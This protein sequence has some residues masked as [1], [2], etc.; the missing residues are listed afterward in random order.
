MTKTIISGAVLSLVAMSFNGCG[1]TTSTNLT[2]GEATKVS[3]DFGE[4][5]EKNNELT[6]RILIKTDT[7]E[8]GNSEEY[9]KD[10][11]VVDNNVIRHEVKDKPEANSTVSIGSDDVNITFPLIPSKNFTS[12]RVVEIGETVSHST[13]EKEMTFSGVTTKTEEEKKCILESKITTFDVNASLFEETYTGDIIVIACTFNEKVSF[14]DSNETMDTTDI[15]RIYY[16]KEKG[17]ILSIDN[18]C[19]VP[20]NLISVIDDSSKECEY[21]RS[22][23][24][25]LVK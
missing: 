21:K 13:S 10:N 22:T 16:Q 5:F 15:E 18:N 11:V 25:A 17:R 7:R 19:Y 6:N 12:K 2:D 24:D 9:Y 20:Q 14:S 23:I 1:E 3:I 4:Y 8:N